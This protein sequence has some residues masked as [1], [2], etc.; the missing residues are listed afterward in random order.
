MKILG[1]SGSMTPHSKTMITIEKALQFAEGAAS[2]VTTELITLGDLE[3]QFCDGRDP[4]LYGGDTGDLIR[5]IREAD[6]LIVGTPIYRGSYT[7]ALKNVMDL[8]PN[9]A[10]RG[11]V[12]GL[13]AT[14]GTYHHF[15][16]IEHQLKPL[17]GYFQAH[18]VPG[19]V[20]AHN[21]HFSKDKRLEDKDIIR[22][23][24]KLGEDVVHLHNQIHHEA[25]A[26]TGPAVPGKTF[27]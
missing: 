7:G 12:I 4:S 27:P 22:R 11:K 5:K 1:L 19:S 20:Y 10:L 23:V 25:A 8:I 14:G 9:D 6:A 2:N 16:A 26:T 24:E 13:V 15:L 18:I 17:F 3:L 21:D